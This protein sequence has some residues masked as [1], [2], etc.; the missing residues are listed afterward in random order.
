MMDSVRSENDGMET[1]IEPPLPPLA[2]R[3]PRNFP[4][5]IIMGVVFWFLVFTSE[6]A[7]A[8]Y[9]LIHWLLGCCIH[10]AFS[11][12]N[13]DENISFLSFIY[14]MSSLGAFLSIMSHVSGLMIP[15]FVFCSSGAL[16]IFVLLNFALLEPPGGQDYFREVCER[17]N[18][19]KVFY[20]GMVEHPTG[21][22]IKAILVILFFVVTCATIL[23]QVTRNDEEARRPQPPLPAGYYPHMFSAYREAPIGATNLDEP[24]RYSVNSGTDVFSTETYYNIQRNLSTSIQLL[25]ANVRKE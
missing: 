23:F 7:F 19:T 13:S 6:N 22:M 21:T 17:S 4:E 10:I 9:V 11:G 1:A 25:G 20:D 24:P 3:R 2:R 5:R 8:F 14:F 15:L 12:P 18:A 16:F